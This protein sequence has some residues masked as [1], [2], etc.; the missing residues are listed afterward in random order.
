MVKRAV[1]RR[2]G[3]SLRCTIVIMDALLIYKKTLLCDASRKPSIHSSF[4]L[5]GKE[6]RLDFIA[7]RFH[8]LPLPG[9]RN[10][11]IH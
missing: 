10:T 6:Q 9:T 1:V 11:L 2:D 3:V 7:F 8:E 5:G 4:L